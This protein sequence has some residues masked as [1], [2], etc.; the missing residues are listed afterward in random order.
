MGTWKG[1]MTYAY[2]VPFVK[3]FLCPGKKEGTI[4][5]HMPCQEMGLTWTDLHAGAHALSEPSL[6]VH[7]DHHWASLGFL[8]KGNMGEHG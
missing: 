7:L 2:V 5:C 4:N 1:V 6:C 8:T 3:R